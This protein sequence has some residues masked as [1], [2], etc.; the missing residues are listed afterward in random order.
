MNL[1]LCGIGLDRLGVYG[2]KGGE[3]EG[4]GGAFHIPVWRGAYTYPNEGYTNNILGDLKLIFSFFIYFYD[5]VACSGFQVFIYS[6]DSSTSDL[7][8]GT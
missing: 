1:W 8:E 4:G 7:F 6:W 3:R 2:S 5:F